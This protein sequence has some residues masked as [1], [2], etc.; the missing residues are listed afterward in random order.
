MVLPTDVRRAPDQS[1]PQVEPS[2]AALGR[3]VC[4]ATR[5]LWGLAEQPRRVEAGWWLP[6]VKCAKRRSEHTGST[7]G[8]AG[9]RPPPAPN[10]T[11]REAQRGFRARRCRNNG[12]RRLVV[13]VDGPRGSSTS[14]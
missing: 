5:R 2:C 13:T 1:R 8:S 4:L 12:K 3:A 11:E 9:Q 10:A 7:R 14:R 6:A